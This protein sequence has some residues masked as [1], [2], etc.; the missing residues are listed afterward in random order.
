MTTGESLRGRIGLHSDPSNPDS[1][2]QSD[3][4]QEPIEIW[5][6]PIQM[7]LGRCEGPILDS[8]HSKIQKGKGAT[9]F[10]DP[11]QTQ[12]V[13]VLLVDGNERMEVYNPEKHGE[14]DAIRDMEITPSQLLEQLMGFGVEEV[15]EGQQ[16]QRVRKTKGGA[17]RDHWP[18][19]HHPKTR[20]IYP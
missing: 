18:V 20:K 10:S 4:P 13:R 5:D 9:I 11:E 17:S 14:W 16:F 7:I 1:I 2:M 3:L 19:D 12:F 8:K 6:E 15:N